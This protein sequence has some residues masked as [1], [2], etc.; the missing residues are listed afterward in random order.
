MHILFFHY[1]HS[2]F[3]IFFKYILQILPF[4]FWSMLVVICLISSP[5][6]KTLIVSLVHTAESVGIIIHSIYNDAASFG[7]DII[8]G[9]SDSVFLIWYPII[10]L[11]LKLTEIEIYR[12]LFLKTLHLPLS[13]NIYAQLLRDAKNRLAIWTKVDHDL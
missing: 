11:I 8:F 1:I 10:S 2:E 13:L 4:F 5:V 6:P 9:G 12:F 3:N 7:F